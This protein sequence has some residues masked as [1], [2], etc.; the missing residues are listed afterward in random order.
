MDKAVEAYK[1]GERIDL[2]TYGPLR[3]KRQ[4]P[5]SISGFCVE[6]KGELHLEAR[7]GDPDGTELL[8]ARGTGRLEEPEKLGKEVT[9]Q[10]ITKGADKILELFRS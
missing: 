4:L 9:N 8:V 1:N 2:R 10:L 3:L 7:I 5:C 6:K